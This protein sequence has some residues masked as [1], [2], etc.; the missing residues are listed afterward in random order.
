M[1]DKI[2]KFNTNS[3][4]PGDWNSAWTEVPIPREDW[5][6]GDWSA[7]RI[8]WVRFDDTR[9]QGNNRPLQYSVHYTEESVSINIEI[10]G[11][12]FIYV[13]EGSFDIELESGE[14]HSFTAGDA[15]HFRSGLKG[16]WT[17]HAPF[18]QVVAIAFDHAVP[19]R[20]EVHPR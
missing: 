1:N 3:K 20:T 19:E 13:I 7:G 5:V 14:K 4:D 18:R 11:D 16:T 17:Y 8:R 15:I 9:D 12:E 6:S 10:H 2:V